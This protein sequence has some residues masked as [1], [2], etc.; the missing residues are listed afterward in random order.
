[1]GNSTTDA[2]VLEA[3]LAGLGVARAWNQIHAMLSPTP[4][5][6]ALKDGQQ[7]WRPKT[8]VLKDMQKMPNCFRRRSVTPT[9]S[10]LPLAVLLGAAYTVTVCF[11]RL[12]LRHALLLSAFSLNAQICASCISPAYS[13]SRGLVGPSNRAAEIDGRGVGSAAVG[14]FDAFWVW[15]CFGS[16]RWRGLG[17]VETDLLVKAYIM[18]PTPCK[19]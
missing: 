19:V 18:S 8:K 15:F 6:P 17:L 5:R 16:F 2:R 11:L 12:L 14:V 10:F 1:M 4:T 7:R 9:S 13:V 3:Q